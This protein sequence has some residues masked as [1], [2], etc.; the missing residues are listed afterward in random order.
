MNLAGNEGQER[1]VLILN[2]LRSHKRTDLFG[3]FQD[4]MRQLNVLTCAISHVQYK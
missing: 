1:L 3:T 4:L 2:H